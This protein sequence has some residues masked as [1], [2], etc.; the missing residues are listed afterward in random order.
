[1]SATKNKKTSLV[2]PSDEP[3]T[4]EGFVKVIKEAEK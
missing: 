2:F 1:M 4:K 3:L